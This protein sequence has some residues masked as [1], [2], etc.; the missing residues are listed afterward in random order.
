[1]VMTI[2]K[3]QLRSKP[4]AVL[5]N[6]VALAVCMPDE[7]LEPRSIELLE[8]IRYYQFIVPTL[9][10]YE[11]ANSLNM[12]LRR[13]RVTQKNVALI[14]S[15]LEKL[16][17]HVD[18]VEQTPMLLLEVAERYALTAYDAAYL[19]LALRLNA[20]LATND[21]QLAAA[22]KLAGLVLL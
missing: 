13:K 16:C 19:E 8:T 1:M 12:G 2:A 15:E 11:F 3:S 14:F 9:W 4:L 6:S 5:D 10:R 21:K 22:A 18:G 17:V 20:R 7:Q